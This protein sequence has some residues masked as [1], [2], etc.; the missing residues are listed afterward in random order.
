MARV[1]VVGASVGG[2][3]AAT[4]LRA[5]GVE[6]LLLERELVKAKPCGGAVP[7]A[8]F[9]EFDLPEHLIDRKVRNAM[10][11]SPSEQSAAIAVAGSKPSPNDYIAMVRREVFDGYLRERAQ[12]RGATLL[13]GTLNAIAVHAR[14]V[15]V[16]WTDMAGAEHALSVD[17]VIGA[18]G[19]Y[20]TVA[21]QLGLP[22]VPRAVAIQERIALPPDKMA[23]WED[24]ADLYLGR[25]TSPDL[26]AWAFP[27]RDH[28]AVG[29]G[30]GPSHTKQVKQLLE[31]TKLRLGAALGGGRVLLR[32][33]H[34]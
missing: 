30:V 8:A 11:F 20:S 10:V 25:A 9:S 28:V 29:I 15:D 3:T 32:E 33:A 19:A 6:T 14:G 17:A 12:Q 5:A 27:K 4:A 24:T 18:D 16:R 21:K 2:A 22:P 26:Y 1:L 7:P 13:H 31:N 23:R 34:A